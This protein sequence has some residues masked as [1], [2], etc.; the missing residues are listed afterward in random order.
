MNIFKPFSALVLATRSVFQSDGLN[1]KIILV[2][3]LSSEFLSFVHIKL[4]QESDRTNMMDGQALLY[5]FEPKIAIIVVLLFE[6]EYSYSNVELY[7]CV[8]NSLELV[9]T[10]K[11]GFGGRFLEA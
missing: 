4:I 3:N 6:A 5:I 9:K 8:P 7:F 11:Y 10:N 1:L 2:V